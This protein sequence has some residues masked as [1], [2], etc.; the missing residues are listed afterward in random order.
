MDFSDVLNLVKSGSKI[1][2]EGWNGNGMFV[3]YQ[4][5]YPD[6]IAINR[7][8]ANATGIPEGTVKSFRP[9]LMMYTAQ[10]D[11]VPW[12][13]SQTDILAEDWITA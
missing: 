2:R 7:N 6:G 8:T 12:V 5:G 10:G 4:P 11:F 1:A 3:V 9:Y 13:A